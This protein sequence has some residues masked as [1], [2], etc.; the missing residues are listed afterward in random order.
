VNATIYIDIGA[1]TNKILPGLIDNDIPKTNEMNKISN[2]GI[3]LF[4]FKLLIDRIVIEVIKTA[5]KQLGAI[6]SLLVEKVFVRYKLPKE[7]KARERLV[8]VLSDIFILAKNKEEIAEND[9]IHNILRALFSGKI[10][11]SHPVP[12]GY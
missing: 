2:K 6:E 10:L 9:N 7:D 4:L 5:I 3:F 1:I 12:G 8:K 11:R